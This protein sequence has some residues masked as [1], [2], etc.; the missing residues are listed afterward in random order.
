M[1]T[2]G[3]TT[4]GYVIKPSEV[5]VDELQTGLRGAF[6]AN[7]DLTPS[8]NWQQLVAM[9]AD[10]FEELWQLGQALYAATDPDKATDAALIALCAITGTLPEAAGPSSVAAIATGNPGTILLA[11]RKASVQVTKVPFSSD[12]DATL[13]AAT[14]WAISTAYVIGDIRK[15]NSAIFYCT[16][17]GTSAGSGGPS[18]QG[19]AIVDGTVTW[20][21]VGPGTAYAT[22]AWTCTSTGPLSALSGTLT[23]IDTTVSGWLGVS[24]PSD[25]ALGNNADTNAQLRQRR[26]QELLGESRSVVDSIRTRILEDV[27]S[28]TNCIVLTNETEATNGDGMPPHSVE[29]LVRGGLDQDIVDTIFANVAAGISTY[30]NQT[31]TFTD[32][33]NGEQTY[34][35]KWSRPVEHQIYIIANVVKDGKKFPADGATRIAASLAFIGN[36]LGE[37]RDVESSYLNGFVTVEATPNDETDE[38]DTTPMPGVLRVTSLFIGTSPSPASEASIVMAIRDLARFDTAHITVNLSDTTP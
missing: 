32:V 21:F 24:N 10:R 17:G 37:G 16:I 20:R 9:L 19:T 13:G 2:Y 30:G 8:S 23:N 7:I 31:G 28:V 3:L 22:I 11:G 33:D 18:G 26:Q 25:A 34:T 29:C 1:T 15:N 14:A 4:T 36:L 5:I 38:V 6:G 12:A 35:V 27:D